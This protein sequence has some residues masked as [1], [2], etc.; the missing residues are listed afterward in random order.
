MFD[1]SQKAAIVTG[2]SYGLGEVFAKDLAKAGC[3][4]TLTARSSDLLEA[5]ADQCRE[6]GSPKV[7]TVTGDVSVEAD[8]VR[9]VESAA[10]IA[11]ASTRV[12]SAPNNTALI[13][14]AVVSSICAEICF[15]W[16]RVEARSSA[17]FA[18]ALEDNSPLM[19]LLA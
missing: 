12:C 3:A 10:N 19:V 1:Y 5:V 17:P 11:C 8:V 13:C 2:A 7:I 18:K 16:P 9:V 15:I 6:L 4:L 14:G